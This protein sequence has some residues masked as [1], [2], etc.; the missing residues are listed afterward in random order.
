[1]S[2]PSLEVCPEDRR[3]LSIEASQETNEQEAGSR[4]WAWETE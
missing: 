3:A 1:M 2:S 4:E